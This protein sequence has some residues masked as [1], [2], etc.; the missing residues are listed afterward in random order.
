MGAASTWGTGSWGSTVKQP[1]T[2]PTAKEF[3]FADLLGPSVSATT[4]P[5]KAVGGT[6]HTTSLGNSPPSAMQPSEYQ[7]KPPA[8]MVRQPLPPTKPQPKQIESFQPIKIDNS[9]QNITDLFSNFGSPP[10]ANGQPAKVAVPKSYV[11]PAAVSKPVG[12]VNIFEMTIDDAPVHKN[13]HS[14]PVITNL[15][16]VLPTFQN[17]K[18]ISESTVRSASHTMSSA[19]LH[20]S[21]VVGVG[22]E[23]SKSQSRPKATQSG[24]KVVHEEFYDIIPCAKAHTRTLFNTPNVDIVIT[25]HEIVNRNFFVPDYVLYHLLTKGLNIQVKRK[26]AH[27]VRLRNMLCKF[28]PGFRVPYL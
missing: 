15:S 17:Q 2:A 27:F 3:N 9:K 8:A 5:V 10:P 1:T 18:Q 23:R 13:N 4:S 20:S 16:G 19:D 6:A 25:G 14:E 7:L 12:N 22:S 11:G 28:Y 24:I 26:Y 21:A